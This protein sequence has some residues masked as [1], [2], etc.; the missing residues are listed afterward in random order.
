MSAYHDKIYEFITKVENFEPYAELINHYEAIRKRL[1][2]DFWTEVKEELAATN[3]SEW[4]VWIDD[5]APYGNSKVGYFHADYTK[6]SDQTSSC[7]I[8]FERLDSSPVYGVWFNRG[9]G[10]QDINF[11]AICEYVKQNHTVWNA[12]SGNWWFAGY[13]TTPDNFRN[14]EHLTRILPEQRTPVVKEYA[15]YLRTAFE[16]FASTGLKFAKKF[17]S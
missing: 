2:I 8:I 14:A 17:T 16:E 15:A 4:K 5:N 9:T 13:K 10:V 1:L 7:L 6:D 12:G 3:K 11:N